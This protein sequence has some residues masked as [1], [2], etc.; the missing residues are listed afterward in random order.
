MSYEVLD[1]K[2]ITSISKIDTFSNPWRSCT[3]NS[4]NNVLLYC[5]MECEIL[6]SVKNAK[7]LKQ[8][9]GLLTL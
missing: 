8:S 3:I 6:L 2:I 1:I 4:T 5:S 7:L 9:V